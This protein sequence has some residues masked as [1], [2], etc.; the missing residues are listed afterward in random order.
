MR[1]EPVALTD[2]DLDRVEEL[3]SLDEQILALAQALPEPSRQALSDRVIQERS[4][5]G[6]RGGA[7][8]TFMEGPG[9]H[10]SA[11]AAHRRGRKASLLDRGAG[12]TLAG[13]DRVPCHTEE[14][15]R[16]DIGDDFAIG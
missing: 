1:L 10:Q 5:G 13:H 4:L 6:E 9:R 11:M 8:P 3:A 2:A 12:A 7:A 15:S 14:P 16:N